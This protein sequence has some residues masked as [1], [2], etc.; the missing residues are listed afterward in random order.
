MR[1]VGFRAVQCPGYVV[2]SLS[3]LDLCN[4]MYGLGRW[5]VPSVTI[6]RSTHVRNPLRFHCTYP[7]YTALIA[8]PFVYRPDGPHALVPMLSCLCDLSHYSGRSDICS[9]EPLAFGA[10]SPFSL[11]FFVG[12]LS[13]GSD[14]VIPECFSDP[15]RFLSP[16][17]WIQSFST[18]QYFHTFRPWSNGTYTKTKIVCFLI[19]YTKP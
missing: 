2:L 6:T 18:H 15:I 17:A 9:M 11:S 1:P 4:C 7:V 13:S 5:P 14:Y 3:Y 16:N 12:R 10:Y 8:C 19:L